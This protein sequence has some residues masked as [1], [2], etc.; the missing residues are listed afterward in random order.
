[1]RKK[2]GDLMKPKNRGKEKVRM[3]KM[4]LIVTA[5]ML[6]MVL[7]VGA[8][9]PT[10]FAIVGGTAVPDGKYPFVAALLDERRTGSASNQQFCGGSLIDSDSV[11]TAAHCVDGIFPTNLSVVV[12]RTQLSINQG[13]LRE[14]TRMYIPDGYNFNQ[15]SKNDVAV[16]RLKSPVTGIDPVRLPQSNQ[17]AAEH[18]GKSQTIVGWGHTMSGGAGTDRMQVVKVPVVSDADAAK[19]YSNFI[20]E[21]MIAAGEKGKDACQGDSGGPLLATLAR[22]GTPGSPPPPP[23]PYQYGITSFGGTKTQPC[24]DNP[25]VYTEVNAPSIREFIT[26]S[27]NK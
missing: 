13:Q 19:L 23:R 2:G 8:A 12:G 10:A 21:L 27:M 4:K 24:G 6:A 14:V 5:V 11:L 20:P 1:V 7:W 15:I 25:G 16:L 3:T 26:T 9:T 18:A 17:N 22:L